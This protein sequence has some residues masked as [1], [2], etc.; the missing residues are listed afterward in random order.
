[1]MFTADWAHATVIWPHAEYSRT[2]HTLAC[3]DSSGY[4]EPRTGQ[5]AATVQTVHVWWPQWNNG[6]FSRYTIWRV[7]LPHSSSITVFVG[8]VMIKGSLPPRRG[9]WFPVCRKHGSVD[10]Y[11]H[12]SCHDVDFRDFVF[13]F[14]D[15][16]CSIFDI[17]S[18]FHLNFRSSQCTLFDTFLSWLMNSINWPACHCMVFIAQMVEYCSVNAEA[19]GLN[20]VEAP[21]SFLFFGLILQLLKLLYNYDDHVFIPFVFPQFTIHLIFM[22]VTYIM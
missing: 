13:Y 10:F 7:R 21:K 1:M 16:M 5:T 17:T 3:L 6:H 19:K 20:P 14:R 22:M 2:V 8:Q 18:S 9:A 12:F 4:H 15:F 11:Y